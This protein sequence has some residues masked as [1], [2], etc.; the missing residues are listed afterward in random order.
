MDP[1]DFAV[2]IACSPGSKYEKISVGC[3]CSTGLGHSAYLLGQVNTINTLIF[4]A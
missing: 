4:I 3:I 2:Q 1:D